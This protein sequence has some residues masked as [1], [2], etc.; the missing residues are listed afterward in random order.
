MSNDSS[1]SYPTSYD[2]TT[3][4]APAVDPAAFTI[5]V[6]LAMV[7]FVF[8]IVSLWKLF[9]KA[10]KPGWA[11]IVPFYNT[12][13]FVEIAKLS[14]VWFVLT[15]IPLVNIIAII[16]IYHGISKA[17]G[18]GAGTTV[19]TILFP[20]VMFPYLAFNKNVVYQG[21]APDNLAATG[22]TSPLP[23]TNTPPTAPPT[24]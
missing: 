18:K 12:W 2:Y 11:A 21:E 16:V 5:G 1:Y 22:V 7:V 9:T 10:G 19:L 20:Y 23:P 14:V 15:F 24:V 13:V 4:T 3:S 8:M 17:F 6:L